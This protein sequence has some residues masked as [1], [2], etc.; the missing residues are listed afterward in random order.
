[1]T[2]IG[3]TREDRDDTTVITVSGSVDV[4]TAP[5]LR[6]LLKSIPEDGTAPVSLVADLDGVTF[7][8]GTGVGVLVGAMRAQEARG[9][10]FGI[11]CSAE[12]VVRVLRTMGLLGR[13]GVCGST[14]GATR[15]VRG[16][17]SEP[18]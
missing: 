5:R 14:D 8:D 9:G 7:L 12:P 1:M 18:R 4:Y 15:A 11:V 13:M 6:E 10:R 16:E 3:L 17:G 2:P